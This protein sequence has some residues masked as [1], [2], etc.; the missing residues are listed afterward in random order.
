MVKHIDAK[1]IA[2]AARCKAVSHSYSGTTI[3]QLNEKFNDE[4]EK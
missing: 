2:K 1:K 4:I 3:H